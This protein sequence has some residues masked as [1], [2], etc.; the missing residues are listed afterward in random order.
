MSYSDIKYNRASTEIL[1][2][3]LYNIIDPWEGCDYTQ[4][5]IEQA[6][7]DQPNETIDYLLGIIEDLQA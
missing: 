5:E 1:A 4:E 7:I 2:E 3:R 6:I